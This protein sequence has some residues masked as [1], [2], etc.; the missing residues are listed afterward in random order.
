[1]RKFVIS[2][3]AVAIMTGAAYAQATEFYVV[4]DTSTKR[5]TIVDKKPTATTTV[6]VGDGKVFTT[7]TEA[8]AG[9]KTMK[10]CTTN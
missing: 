7:R 5:C 10:I 9:M 2:I 6:V 8:E 4:Q 3:G 1:M